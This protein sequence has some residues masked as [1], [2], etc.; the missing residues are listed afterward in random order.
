MVQGSR[1]GFG[2]AEQ[3]KAEKLAQLHQRLAAATPATKRP[4]RRHDWNGRR[5]AQAAV[6]VAILVWAIVAGSGIF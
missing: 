1:D 6:L 4:P 5:T 3:A 2:Q